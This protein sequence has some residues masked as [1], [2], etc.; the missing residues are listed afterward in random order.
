MEKI[1]E[2]IFN[3]EL[4]DKYH[5]KITSLLESEK[6]QEIQE[7][8]E[9]FGNHLITTYGRPDVSRYALWHALIGS[10]IVQEMSYVNADDLSGPDS[11]AS[12]INGLYDEYKDYLP[13]E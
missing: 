8:I 7:K 3:K 1:P 9:R 4:Y 13:K 10:T 6:W 12:F 2:Q 5:D 11:I